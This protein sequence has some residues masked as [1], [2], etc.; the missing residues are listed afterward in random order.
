[1]I[2]FKQFLLLEGGNVTID[3]QEADRIDLSKLNRTKIVAKIDT[4]LHA[5]NAAFRKSKGKPIWSDTLFK[6]KKFLSGSAFHFFSKAIDDE[7]FKKHKGSVGDIDTQVDKNMDADIK[8]WLTANKGKSFG[9]ITL[10]GFKTSA[11]QH[12]SLWKLN[13]EGINIQIDL[14]MVD[15]GEDDHPTEWAN[16][17]HSSAWEDMTQGVKGVAHKYLLRALDAPKLKDIVLKAKTARGTDK[18]VKSSETAFSVT[19][20]VRQKIKPVLD[21]D[22]KQLIINGKPAYHEMSTAESKGDTSLPNIFKNYFNRAATPDDIKKLSSFTGLLELINKTF[23]TGDKQ[24]ITDGFAR[25]LWGPQAQGLYKGD[26]E[27][28]AE[29]KN[30]M[31]KLLTKTLASKDTYSA[32]RKEFYDN[33]K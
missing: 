13:D 32:D 27:K 8:D 17:S 30:S 5:I 20:G 14:E 24:K 31:M 10:I 16:F 3:D 18:E 29:E 11:G 22:G 1:M 12:I 4:A 19:H 26:P 21:A 23:K 7:T 25:T 15:F 28:D 2:T 33:Y 6:S 9:P